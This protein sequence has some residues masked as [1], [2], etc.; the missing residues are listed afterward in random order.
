ME[1]AVTAQEANY[2]RY[3]SGVRDCIPLLD[4]AVAG[5]PSIYPPPEIIEKLE[6]AI[7][8]SGARRFGRRSD[9]EPQAR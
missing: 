9:L 5:D 3:A 6:P 4:P 2:A 8:L 1:P 7:P